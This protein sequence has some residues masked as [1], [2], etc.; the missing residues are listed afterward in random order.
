MLPVDASLS[1]TPTLLVGIANP[2]TAP[3]LMNLAACL[4][5]QAGASVVATHIVRVPP[6]APLASARANPRTAAARQLLRAALGQC[7]CAG[8]PARGV[9]EMARQVHEG[10][11]SAADS[12]R[13]TLILVGLSELD[14]DRETSQRKFDR[15]MHR[16]ARGAACPV[17]VA[18]FRIP[19]ESRVLLSLPGNPDLDLLEWVVRSLARRPGT[20]LQFLHVAARDAKVSDTS[21]SLEASLEQR[22]LTSLGE[23]EIVT[24]ESPLDETLNRAPDYDLV[25]VG[26]GASQTFAESVFGSWAERFTVQTPTNVLLV[27]AST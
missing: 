7:R 25:V 9:V 17:M 23:V 22:G 15:V 6:Q 16:V 11:L 26:G 5:Q 2:E 3:R 21:S 27:H 19:A 20:T 4:A 10:L 1:D 18:K 14:P 8:Q 24:G 13:A 12:Q